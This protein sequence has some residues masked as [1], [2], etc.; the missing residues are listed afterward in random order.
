M[1]S[2][3][4][5]PFAASVVIAMVLTA[6]PAAAAD[7]NVP[8]RKSVAAVGHH[9]LRAMRQAAFR[10]GDHRLSSFLGGNLGCSGIW[11]GRQFVLIVG[12]GY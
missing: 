4:M 2:R 10:D 6:T 5:L 12:I 11:C 7:I 1:L 3:L 8:V 9:A